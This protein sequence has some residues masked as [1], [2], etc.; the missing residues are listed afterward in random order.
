L[1]D[2]SRQISWVHYGDKTWVIICNRLDSE[3]KPAKQEITVTAQFPK[4]KISDA[5]ENNC[6]VR[7]LTYCNDRWV[8]VTEKNRDVVV[9]QTVVT[10]DDIEDVKSEI[11]QW[12]NANKAVHSLVWGKVEGQ[13]KW[14]M[15]SQQTDKVPG[16]VFTANSDWPLE[17]IGEHFK[18]GKYIST[19]AY[20]PSEEFWVVIGG[21]L[22]G[23]QSMAT[24]ETFPYA[25]IKTLEDVYLYGVRE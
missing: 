20:H 7:L 2:E 10:L 18:S 1:E 6:K 21:P 19:L 22:T 25:K 4:N 9:G 17:K 5:W 24:T 8:L 15:V 14:V 12:W 3:T 11:R 13:D 23:G 16:Q